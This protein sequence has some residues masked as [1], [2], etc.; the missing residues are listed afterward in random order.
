MKVLLEHADPE[1][2][3][4]FVAMAALNGLDY[5]DE[6]ARPVLDRVTALPQRDPKMH[7]KY[8][9]YL[10]NLIGKIREDLE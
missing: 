2:N 5:M 6:R 1:R 9:A 3:G 8:R 7:S 4:V 10:P